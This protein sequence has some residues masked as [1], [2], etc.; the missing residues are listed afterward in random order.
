MVTV[1]VVVCQQGVWRALE[2]KRQVHEMSHV[3]AAC[4]K[5]GVEMGVFVEK[6]PPGG[7]V[8]E[9][10]GRVVVMLKTL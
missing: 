6:H 4:R 2:K 7:V 3:E 1:K 8:W 5:K 9:W 10:K